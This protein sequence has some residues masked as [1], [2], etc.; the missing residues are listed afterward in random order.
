VV[1][2]LIL[3]CKRK[4]EWSGKEHK[5]ATGELNKIMHK[6]TAEGDSLKREPILAVLWCNYFF[7]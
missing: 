7:E 1:T 6:K 5:Y 2:E 4:L 3:F